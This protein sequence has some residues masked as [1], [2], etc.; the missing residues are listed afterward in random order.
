[1]SKVKNIVAQI[2][3]IVVVSSS[4][5]LFSLI[6]N[7]VSPIRLEAAKESPVLGNYKDSIIVKFKD[8]AN[9]Q[10]S[11]KDISSKLFGKASVSGDQDFLKSNNLAV[12]KPQEGQNP[13]QIIAQLKT[14]P[15][16]QNAQF[17]Y[18]YKTT[19]NPGYVPNDPSFATGQWN[20]QDSASGIYM[21]SA[22][23]ATGRKIT[24]NNS[25]VCSEAT[26]S[27]GGSNTVKV[28][29]IDSGVNV[30]SLAGS[31]IDVA[32]S[33][34]FYIGS[35]CQPGEV[36]KGDFPANSGNYY[37]QTIGGQYDDNDHGTRVASIISMADDSSDGIGIGYN[38]QLLPLAIDKDSL[39]T[40]NL[41]FALDYAIN[42]GV[43]VINLSL[44]TPFN[45]SIMQTWINNAVN[46][47]I[48]VVASS[49]NCGN[50]VSQA[51]FN[52]GSG[53]SPGDEQYGVFN[54]KVYPAYYSNV[55]SVGALNWNTSTST[56]SRSSYS[57]Y[58]DEVDVAVPV[59]RNGSGSILT[60][61]S[62]SSNCVTNSQGTSFAAPQV[63]GVA[64]LLRSIY[65]SYSIQQIKD[66][67]YFN[68]TDLGSAGRDDQFGFGLLNAGRSTSVPDI[69]LESQPTRQIGR[70]I[71]FTPTIVDYGVS[72][73]KAEYFANNIK[74]GES[75]TS[76]FSFT[77]SKNNVD[78]GQYSIYAKV[79]NTLNA[80]SSS[81]RINLNVDDI[82]W[83]SWSSTDSTQIFSEINQA[84]FNGRIYQTMIGANQGISTRF[85]SDG[86]TWSAWVVLGVANEVPV[87]YTYN[88]RL[89]QTIRGMDRGIWTRFTS[90]GMNWSA[91]TRTG[92][93]SSRPIGIEF[94]GY[95]YEAVK[96]GRGDGI[97][98]RRGL[99]SGNGT[100]NWEASVNSGITPSFINMYVF[101]NR[102]YQSIYGFDR[103]IYTRSTL[104]GQL[105]TPWTSSGVTN[106]VPTFVDTQDS[107]G[108]LYQYIR[109]LDTGIWRRQ[110]TDGVN[111]GSWSKIGITAT[112]INAKVFD[113]KLFEAVGGLDQGI[114]TRFALPGSQFFGSTRSG[115][116]TS[117]IS[118][119]IINNRIVQAIRGL[120]NRVYFRS[121]E[122]D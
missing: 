4:I 25:L 20:L 112:R 36:S 14:D 118:M 79:T 82:A 66:L 90:D 99:D 105:W 33:A 84:S 71:I 7:S 64:G 72:I 76:P 44:G 101:K 15:A 116:V 65:P 96:G 75:T 31:N 120:D 122:A 2:T 94:K 109:G 74:I 52:F 30:A 49:G 54:P 111:W 88:N 61:C 11:T 41:V 121:R 47:G 55:I 69:S 86:I 9:Q 117:P 24:A 28:A 104:D 67:I 23:Q 26:P 56:F 13:D 78:T 119:E 68:T 40:L 57:T 85:S 77:W 60:K 12:V 1:M 5:G 70:D 102:L 27:C 110:T 48:V 16:V 18:P 108:T 89:Y 103:G 98:T 34:R 22:W 83:T 19:T 50:S 95:L 81:A 87:L 17:N 97:W 10:N 80:S 113:S 73:S 6:G 8:E 45:D 115:I 93:T 46:N 59:D 91:W 114:W 29:V 107:G 63:A 42:K 53:Y 62:A 3:S 106:E 39:N 51:C 35:G 32:N 92:E 38:T 37:C 43:K 21:P 58:N 100:I